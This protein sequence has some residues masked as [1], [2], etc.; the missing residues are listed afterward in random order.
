MNRDLIESYKQQISEIKVPRTT[1]AIVRAKQGVQNVSKTGGKML[2]WVADNPYKTLGIAL[3]AGGAVAGGIAAANYFGSDSSPPSPENAKEEK[4]IKKLQKKEMQ[5]RLKQEMANIRSAGE[6]DEV[7][8]RKKAIENLGQDKDFVA[9]ANQM[10]YSVGKVSGSESGMFGYRYGSEEEAKKASDASR[11]Q[12]FDAQGRAKVFERDP[13]GKLVGRDPTEA[14]V[15]ARKQR[16]ASEPTQQGGRQPFRYINPNSPEGRIEAQIQS[17]EMPDIWTRDSSGR[18]IQGQGLRGGKL[19]MDLQ[20]EREAAGKA[21]YDASLNKSL[22]DMDA[23]TENMI[24]NLQMPDG[25]SVSDQ[26]KEGLRNWTKERATK[27]R[28]QLF[29]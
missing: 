14:E 7:A 4:T 2:D 13:S 5:A 11:A 21:A 15:T 18:I 22:A 27:V 24:N 10:G 28:Q 9:Q 1:R 3:G 16:F 25:S 8:I 12:L 29:R 23:E 20:K 26:E 17:G 19:P 6:S